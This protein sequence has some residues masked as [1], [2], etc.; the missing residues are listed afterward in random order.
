MIVAAKIA[1]L[2]LVTWLLIIVVVIAIVA[3]VSRRRV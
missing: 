2:S 3:V 1:G